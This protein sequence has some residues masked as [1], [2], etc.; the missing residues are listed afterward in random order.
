MAH[1]K[2]GNACIGTQNVFADMGK[3]NL[4]Y[5]FQE[6]HS[7]IFFEKTAEILRVQSH[8]GGGVTQADAF[9]IVC[10]YIIHHRDQPGALL[11]VQAASAL[12]R[13]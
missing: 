13:R 4:V 7:H 8:L 6:G 3:T 10:I 2:L 5:E 9:L 1:Q 12:S 11:V